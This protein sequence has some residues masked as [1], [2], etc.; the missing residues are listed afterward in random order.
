MTGYNCNWSGGAG[1]IAFV[2]VFVIFL[3]VLLF[4]AGWAM[5]K[6]Y[7]TGATWGAWGIGLFVFFLFLLVLFA[8]AWWCATPAAAHSGAHPHTI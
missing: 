5:G 8:V 4:G 2:I 3:F 6:Q 7:H 1:A